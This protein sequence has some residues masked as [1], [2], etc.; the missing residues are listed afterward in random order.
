[1]FTFK[2][3]HPA[4]LTAAATTLLSLTAANTSRAV[5]VTGVYFE[6]ARCDVIPQQTL[7]H[8]LG[9][10]GFFPI[11]ESFKVNSVSAA[12]FTV[13]VPDDNQ[14]NDW[15]VDILNTS[16][17]A[18]TN[19]F[20]V[21]DDQ[22]FV[23]NADGT[24]FDPAGPPGIAPTDAFRIDSFGINPNL[25]GESM[26]NDGI[27]APGESWRFNVSNFF[28]ASGAALPPIFQRPGI[29]ANSETVNAAIPGTASILAIP[30]PEPSTIGA[31][32][33]AACA[34]LMQRRPRRS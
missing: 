33:V 7:S 13:C 10:G 5:P 34:I 26:V 19:V 1:M 6:D 24:M 32:T 20:F 25:L 17:T 9:E 2:P 12:T 30:I 16:G 15:I 23:G 14:A 31:L 29:F 27:F 3:Y 4:L 21:A 8:E 22:M 18:W 28:H 11:N